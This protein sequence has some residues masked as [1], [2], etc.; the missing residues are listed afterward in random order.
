[1]SAIYI[2]VGSR[3]SNTS[4]YDF[5]YTMQKTHSLSHTVSLSISLSLSPSFAISL[6]VTDVIADALTKAAASSSS[7]MVCLTDF[8]AADRRGWLLL[9]GEACTRSDKT[10]WA[11]GHIVDKTG[12]PSDAGNEDDLGTLPSRSDLSGK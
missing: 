1:M 2:L 12:V 3:F 11:T 6:C 5:L 10:G 8:P 9:T 7:S 4:I